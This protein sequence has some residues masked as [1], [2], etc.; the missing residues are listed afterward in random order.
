MSKYLIHYCTER[1]WYVR[2]YL[3]PSLK[4]Q[5]ITSNEISVT[6]DYNRA[7]NLEAT[8]HS[9]IELPNTGSTWHIQDDIVISK[10]F[11]CITQ[12]VEKDMPDCIACGFSSEYDGSS[13]IGKTD[14]RGMWYSFPC[15]LIPN[16]VAK[17][18][19]EYYFEN[20]YEDKYVR[21]W[22]KNKKGDDSVFR[23]FLRGFYPKT[24]VYNIVP[25]IV[26]H[27]DD[28]LGGSLANP[29]RTA[30]VKSKYWIEES[31]VEDLKNK[32]R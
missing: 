12:S 19:G 14:V 20:K 30:V 2:D 4:E 21:L 11:R 18:C 1:L 29:Q 25:N 13:A 10:S 5:G 23:H 31:I 8:M 28:L 26:E 16:K 24:S 3:I 22:A 27:V 7:G 15:I 32:L 6:G 9:F 17:E